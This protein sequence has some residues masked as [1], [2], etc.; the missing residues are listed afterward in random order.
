[1]SHRRVLQKLQPLVY[2]LNF[3]EAPNNIRWSIEFLREVRPR[4][5]L[6]LCSI[7]FTNLERCANAQHCP[8]ACVAGILQTL[9]FSCV[10]LAECVRT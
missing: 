2:V 3:P 1:M 6:P 4:V 9:R 8:R 7:L 10:L 5:S